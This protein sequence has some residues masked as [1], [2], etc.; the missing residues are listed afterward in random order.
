MTENKRN[1]PK[2]F[3]N[4]YGRLKGRGLRNL[5]QE[6]LNNQLNKL[7]IPSVSQYFNPDRK[8]I[9]VSDLFHDLASVNLEIGFGGGEHLVYQAKRNPNIGFIGCEPYI[10]AVAMLAGKLS[11]LN[12]ENVRIYPGDVRDL[13]D[14]LPDDSIGNVFLLYPDPWPKKRHHRRRFVTS[15][16]L[17]DLNRVMKT[18]AVLIWRRHPLLRVD[19]NISMDAFLDRFLDGDLYFGD[20]HQHVL[21]WVRTLSPQIRPEQVLVLRYEDLVE[22][23]E[24]SLDR[25][26]QFLGNGRT[27][28]D[29]T[30]ARIA[31]STG[32]R[33]MKQ[34]MTVNPRSFYFNPKVFFRSG[35][36]REWAEQLSPT[37]V[38]RID[39]KTRRVW[40]DMD[41]TCPP[42]ALHRD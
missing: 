30:R 29:E 19:P 1:K 24:A 15:E 3:R 28:D 12:L 8:H 16:Y 10:N 38:A 11:Q 26:A 40:G 33:S 6:I 17:I 21:G 9:E 7:S 20:Y 13:F 2:T 5:Q 37:Q 36:A 41:L 25:L 34:E 23:K 31:A 4:F 27:L 32:F 18:G 39:E 22:N 14:V 35:R 42:E